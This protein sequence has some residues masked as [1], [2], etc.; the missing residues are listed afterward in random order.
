[1]LTGE[2][3]SAAGVVPDRPFS[4]ENGTWGAWELAVRYAN[5]R[6]DDQAFPLFADPAANANEATALG[7]G[8][9]WYLSRTVRAT[10][11][12][13]QTRFSTPVARSSA[14]ALRQD[15]QALITRFQVSF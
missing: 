9:S 14:P 5:L 15:E 11:D 10:F 7:L 13:Y 4:W 2:D 12:Y 1:M 6:I 3:S 8:V